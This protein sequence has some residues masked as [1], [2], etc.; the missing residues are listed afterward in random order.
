MRSLHRKVVMIFAVRANYLAVL[1]YLSSHTVGMNLKPA[2][3]WLNK[4]GGAVQVLEVHS[5]LV[6]LGTFFEITFHPSLEMCERA[7]W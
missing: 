4:L 6:F 1:N 2:I 3:A 7:L 5:F